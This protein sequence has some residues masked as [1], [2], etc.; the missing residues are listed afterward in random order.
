MFYQLILSDNLCTS[1]LPRSSPVT[2]CFL[3][4]PHVDEIGL[5]RQLKKPNQHE[6]K[7]ALFDMNSGIE[8]GSLQ[9]SGQILA[10][11]IKRVDKFANR[12]IQTICAVHEVIN[13]QKSS[14]KLG[15]R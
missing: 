5:S 11:T 12:L 6:H 10:R 8:G 9:T 3:R 2:G 15:S 7:L 14:R 13:S 4:Y 1:G